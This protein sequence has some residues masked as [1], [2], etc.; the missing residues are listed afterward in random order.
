MIDL[1]SDTVTRPVPGM[2]KAMAGAEV[3]DDVF[4]ED[5]TLNLLQEKVAAMLGKEAGLF[6]PSGV[7]ANQVCMKTHTQAGDEV[8][9][10]S[11]AH[12]FQYESGGPAVL[13]GVMCK[14]VFGKRGVITADQVAA[15]IR[16]DNVHFPPTRLVWI[17]NTHNKAGGTVFPQA[18]IIK[19]RAVAD[20][21]GLAMHMDG[22]R[23]WNAHV[24]SGIP[25]EEIARPFDSVSV[26]F[27]KGLGAPVG[28]L[29]AGSR[30][31]IKKAHRWRKVFGGG[32]RQA[33]ILAAASIYAVDHHIPRL[34]EDHDHA[35]KLAGALDALP[36][37]SVD[38]DSVETNI[39][40]LDVSGTGRSGTEI[41]EALRE[42]GV[43]VIAT[44]PHALRAVTHLDVSGEDI[45]RAIGI[46]GQVMG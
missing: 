22:A 13:S 27:S 8:I 7:M 45:D 41:E 40:F 21:H 38:L 35:R 29:I 46:F 19:I 30:D 6:V 10:E 1:R 42:K 44:G 20:T 43:L 28:S 34:A 26:C 11:D 25:L 14:T 23:L 18:E 32:M 3:G 5:P 37:V 2:R 31:F 17:E 36:G 15:A 12:A 9:M 16:G 39:V 33:G 24:A 4:G